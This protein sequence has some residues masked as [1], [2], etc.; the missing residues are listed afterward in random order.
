MAEALA[1]G[2]AEIQIKAG[3]DYWVDPQFGPDVPVLSLGY[4][5]TLGMVDRRKYPES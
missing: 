5:E 3:A 1:N 2:E 4:D